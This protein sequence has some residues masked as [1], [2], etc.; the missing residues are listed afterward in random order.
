MVDCDN[1]GSAGRRDNDNY[2]W[3]F[4]LSELMDLNFQSVHCPA[5]PHFILGLF[6]P[7]GDVGDI[8]PYTPILLQW[9]LWQEYQC[10]LLYYMTAY[11][12]CS[13]SRHPT[14]PSHFRSV[15]CTQLGE[16]NI[17]PSERTLQRIMFH[18]PFGVISSLIY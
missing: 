9:S 14:S 16:Y 10:C 3:L 6:Q 18:L 4:F 13:S 17:T 15:V 7:T 11:L 5:V 12:L 1:E 8:A 2:I